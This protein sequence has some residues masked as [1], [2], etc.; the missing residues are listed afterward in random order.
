MNAKIIYTLT[1]EAPMLATYSLLPIVQAWTRTA[2]VAVET[3]DISLADACWPPFPT[4]LKAGQRCSDDLAELGELAKTPDANIIKLPNISASIPQLVEAIKE[5]QGQ[6]YALP[7]YP[8]SAGKRGTEAAQGALRESLGQR[9]EPGAARGQFGST[10]GQGSQAV[11]ESPSALDGRLVEGL[12]DARGQHG[13]RR[14]LRQRA[15]RVGREGRRAGHR[16]CGRGRQGHR[17][18]G[19]GEGKGQRTDRR[20]F[21]QRRAAGCLSTRARWMRR[22]AM[23]C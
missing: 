7:D 15:I 2:G 12:E 10:C 3:R 19:R 23:A 16:T 4:S 11:R 9:R 17:A 13:W 14:L 20:H 5:L 21:P 1:D 22:S 6:G 8:E 18:E